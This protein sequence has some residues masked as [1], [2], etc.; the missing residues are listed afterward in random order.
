MTRLESPPDI[1]HLSV[2]EKD[3]LLLAQWEEIQRLRARLKE[4]EGQLKKDSRT[5]DKAPSSDGPKAPKRTRSQR[6]KSGRKVGGQPGHEYQGLAPVE[7]PDQIVL[8]EPSQC[9]SCGEDLTAVAPGGYDRRQV[10]DLPPLQLQVTEHRSVCKGCP[11]CGQLSWGAYPEGVNARVQYGPRVQALSVY[12]SDYQ[13]LPYQR[14]RELFGDLFGHELSVGTLQQAKVRCTRGLVPV[15]EAVR[16]ALLEAPVVHFDESG[17]RVGGQRP[18]LHVSSTASLTYYQVH[19]QRGCQAHEA[20][21]LLPVFQGCAVHDSYRSYL[22][23]EHCAHSLCNAHH[24]R[25]LTFMHEHHEQAW[26][27]EMIGCLLE[28]KGAVA[29]AKERGATALPAPQLEAFETRYQ[30]LLDQALEQIPALP[31]PETPRRGR[32][33][34]HPA[35]NLHDRLRTYQ[36]A[37]L[38]FMY[39]FAVPFDNNQAE[40]DIRMLKVQQKISGGF[41]T[42]QGAQRFCAI[43]SYISTVR[44]QGLKVIDALQQVFAGQPWMPGQTAVAFNSS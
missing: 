42:L 13:L 6:K 4:L 34:Q 38:A 7:Q 14:Q 44:K 3:A 37:V 22:T 26:A 39:D 41:R 19:A 20:I 2:S 9:Q 29:E 15:V 16:R 31:P 28:I 12:L 5:S 18:W 23:Y 17:L 33:K 21:G 40:R 36:T 24:L 1:A 43:R 11:V 27:S 8:S 32:K 10:F 35:K 30:Q 25:E